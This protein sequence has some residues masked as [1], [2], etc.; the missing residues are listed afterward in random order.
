MMQKKISYSNMCSL[1]CCC[2]C[3]LLLLLPFYLLLLFIV[4]TRHMHI[5]RPKQQ[6]MKR[7]QHR[8]TDQWK[9]LHS[10][11]CILYT[12]F[13]ILYLF[14]LIDNFSLFNF[15]P[16]CVQA[17][18]WKFFLLTEKTFYYHMGGVFFLNKNE[19]NIHI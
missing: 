13:I 1:P 14:N 6:Q 11:S 8:Q 5:K 18:Q 7:Q 19:T 16:K 17:L 12:Y 3:A 9:F 4:C 15:V 2:C 10:F